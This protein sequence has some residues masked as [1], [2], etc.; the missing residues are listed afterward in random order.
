MR[1]CL[2]FLFV[3]SFSISKANC[4]MSSIRSISED[5]FD[6]EEVVPVELPKSV[7]WVNVKR[8]V[9][10]N[11]ESYK[12]VV[13]MEDKDAGIII[14]KWTSG[15]EKPHSMYW[16]AKYEATYQID[17]RDNKYRIKIY[18][19]SVSTHPDIEDV[20]YMP[21]N[22]VK[23]A[24]KA[25]QT[26]IS[27]SERF[28]NSSQWKLDSKYLEVMNSNTEFT[29]VMESIKNGYNSFNEKILNSLKAA[30]VYVDDF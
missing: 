28:K 27:I 13:D 17:V 23:N 24:K 20:D 6:Y 5:G 21:M 1:R 26:M 14:I 11:F 3:I 2:L 4:L 25:L 10:S 30:M 9:S 22:A 19:A 16:T 12:H 8:W 18:N 29:P 15:E 7:L